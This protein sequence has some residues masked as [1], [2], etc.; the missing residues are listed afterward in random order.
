MERFEGAIDKAKDLVQNVTGGES[1]ADGGSERTQA[2][3]GNGQD[4]RGSGVGT[5]VEVKGPVV[6]VR[7][8]AEE[9]PEIYSALT[10]PLNVDGEE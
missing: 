9:I 8:N 1:A 5:V 10:V 2:A 6:D 3:T 7:F 4:G